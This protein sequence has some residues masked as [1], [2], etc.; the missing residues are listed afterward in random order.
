MNQC[1]GNCIWNDDLLCDRTGV[2]IKEDEVCK[3]WESTE[4]KN[5]KT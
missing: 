1:C 4:A 3:K 2:L 5:L